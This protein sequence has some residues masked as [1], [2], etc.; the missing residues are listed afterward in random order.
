VAVRG[1]AP[2]G[3]TEAWSLVLTALGIPHE[4]AAGPGGLALFVTARDRHRAQA[5]LDA[6]DREAREEAAAAEPPAPD[7]GRSSV[8]VVMAAMLLGFFAVTGE[9]GATDPG[10]WFRQGAA[11]AE[12]IVAGQWWRAVTA[13]TLH[14][15]LSHVAGNAVACLIFVGALGRWLGFGLA[16]L[17]TVVAGALGNVAVAYAYGQLHRSVGASTATFAALGILGGLQCVRWF[18][19]RP[20]GLRRRR[21]AVSI[22]AACLGLFAMLGVGERSDVLAHLFGLAVGL[23]FGLGAGWLGRRGRPTGTVGQTAA[24]L[25]AA[26]LVVGSWWLARR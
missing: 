26:L 17:L 6:S 21:R 3:R 19:G 15:D 2:P 5:A 7:R 9:R 13:L 4:V 1:G 20:T 25:G 24:A 12:A 22:I 14:A 23:A 11:V 18:A 10:G 8:G 16:A